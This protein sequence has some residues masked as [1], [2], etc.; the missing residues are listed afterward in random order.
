MRRMQ[1]GHDD[2]DY[3]YGSDGHDNGYGEPGY[4]YDHERE[5]AYAGADEGSG[6]PRRRRRTLALL[7]AGLVTLALLPV[8]VDR[9]VAARIESRTAKAFQQGMDTPLPPEVHVRGFPVVT[10]AASGTLRRVDITAHDIPAQGTTRPLPVS[11][12]SLRLDGL[13][14]SDDDSEARARSARATASLSYTDVS[15]TLGLEI[16]QGSRPGRVSAV[17]VLPLGGEVTVETSV[18]AVSGNRIAFKDFEVTGGALPAAG[19]L[20]LDRV[21]ERPIPLRNI[22]D[23]LHLRSVTTTADGL[24]ADF[25]GRSVTFRPQ[26]TARDDT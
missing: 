22:P 19:S 25:T 26:D 12:L 10:Q 24:D 1:H 2:Y 18:S 15:D 11:E 8:V 3:G 13:T 23:G 6:E 7:A 20:I 9:A 4:G 17:V 16:S 21:F 14:K 5:N